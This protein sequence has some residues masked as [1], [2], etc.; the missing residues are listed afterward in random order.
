MPVVLVGSTKDD[1]NVSSNPD[2]LKFF[3]NF[4]LPDFVAY[5]PAFMNKKTWS[6]ISPRIFNTD[7]YP[8][9][10]HVLPNEDSFI[11]WKIAI[12][13]EMI[14]PLSNGTVLF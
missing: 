14:G 8:T 9:M 1:I 6:D 4:Q 7:E 12:T 11:Q 3:L 10:Y 2:L 5:N 13:K